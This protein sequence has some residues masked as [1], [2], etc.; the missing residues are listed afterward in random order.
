MSIITP[1]INFYRGRHSAYANGE[2]KSRFPTLTADDVDELA[3]SWTSKNT[4]K[5]TKW[6]IKLIRGE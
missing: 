4:N 5:Q 6:G 1:A 2:G 3:S